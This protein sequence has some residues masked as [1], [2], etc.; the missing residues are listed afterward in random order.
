MAALVLPLPVIPPRWGVPLL[1]LAALA[2]PASR[3]VWRYFLEGPAYG[4]VR[5][6]CADPFANIGWLIEINGQTTSAESNGWP[7]AVMAL[8]L[9]ATLAS[10]GKWGTIAGWMTAVLFVVI[11]GVFTI[12]YAVQVVMDGCMDTLRFGGWHIVE[13]GPI[14]HYLTGAVLVMFL[15]LVRREEIGCTPTPG[16]T[17]P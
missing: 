14:L 3:T 17:L 15:T 12:P 8:G 9:S 5:I 7:T 4:F 2:A 10:R 16:G 13:S 1:S 6:S 11:A